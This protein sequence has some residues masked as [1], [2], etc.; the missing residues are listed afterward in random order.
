GFEGVLQVGVHDDD[1]VA[2]GGVEAGGDSDLVA[3]VAGQ[4]EHLDAGV[5]SGPVEKDLQR[6][7]GAA[8]VDEDQLA[9]AGLFIHERGDGAAEHGQDFL[10]VVGRDDQR[11]AGRSRSWLQNMEYIAHGSLHW[12]QRGGQMQRRPER[13]RTRDRASWGGWGGCAERGGLFLEDSETEVENRVGREPG[14]APVL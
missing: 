5:F 10:L 13:P 1:G 11:Q 12:T 3:E 2:G 6:A 8:V 14:D 9:V 4:A 7:V